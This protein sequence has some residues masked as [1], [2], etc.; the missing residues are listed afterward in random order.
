MSVDIDGTTLMERVVL[1]GVLRQTRRGESPSTSAELRSVCE[2][3]LDSV[4]VE[5]VGRLTEADVTRALNSLAATELVEE[6]LPKRSAVGKGRPSY[7]LAS[8]EAE[9]MAALS[10]D[11]RLEP[12]LDALD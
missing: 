5:V 7:T 2:E 4:D 10:A 11:E 1:L 3:C 8:D 6:A 9:T 12:V